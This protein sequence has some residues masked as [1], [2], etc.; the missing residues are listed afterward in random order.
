MDCKM[1]RPNTTITFTTDGNNR[2]KKFVRKRPWRNEN[3][4]ELSV[5]RIK[6]N[7]QQS[8]FLRGF[9]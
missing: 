9:T 3:F 1:R 5:R 2:K 8:I 7:R 4:L 6:K